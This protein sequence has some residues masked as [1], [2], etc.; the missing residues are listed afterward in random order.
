MS[1]AAMG[2]PTMMDKLGAI[3]V[4]RLSTYDKI[5]DLHRSNSIAR[6]Q[7]SITLFNSAASS[8]LL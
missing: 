7:A 3:K 1:L 8:G 4:I 6:S 5:L 2:A